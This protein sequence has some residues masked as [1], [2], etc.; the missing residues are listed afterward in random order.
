MGFGWR[1][2]LLPGSGGHDHR[3]GRGIG[4]IAFAYA[5]HELVSIALAL[6][7]R[8]DRHF[9]VPPTADGGTE[10]G[11][12]APASSTQVGIRSMM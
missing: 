10:D 8:Y 2:G 3:F 1:S 9:G 4:D 11:Y 12:V 6:D 7:G 5:P